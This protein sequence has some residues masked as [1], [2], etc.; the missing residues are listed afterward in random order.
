ME[1]THA[2]GE[3]ACVKISAEHCGAVIATKRLSIAKLALPA[4][5]IKIANGRRPCVLVERDA[6]EASY[7]VLRRSIGRI[8]VDG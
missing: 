4:D 7:G 8:E 6:F 5:I 2:W 3:R 1:P